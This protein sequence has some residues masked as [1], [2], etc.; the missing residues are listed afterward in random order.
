MKNAKK[1]IFNG[2]ICAALFAA[3]LGYL[4]RGQDFAGLL[5][6]TRAGAR[7]G[8]RCRSRLSWANRASSGT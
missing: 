7:R 6:L 8:W 2:L 3:T 5:A 4:L 1:W